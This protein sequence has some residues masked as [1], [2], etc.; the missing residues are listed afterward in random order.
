MYA[1]YADDDLVYSPGAASSLG[2][3]ASTAKITTEINKAGSLEFTIP[4]TNPSYSK[5]SK[6]K[7][8]RM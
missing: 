3:S 6:L 2:Y 4:P 1:I 8:V 7:M 5:M